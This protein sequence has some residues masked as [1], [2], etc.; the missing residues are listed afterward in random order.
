[1]RAK[2][3][4][5]SSRA[6]HALSNRSARNTAAAAARMVRVLVA[7]RASS[8]QG[9][10][11]AGLVARFAGEQPQMIVIEVEDIIRFRATA[12]EER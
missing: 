4:A 9:N 3:A 5:V 1:M 8:L 11:A 12:S 2:T 7:S 6:L 10:G